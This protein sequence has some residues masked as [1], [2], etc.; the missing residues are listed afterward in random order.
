MDDA[1]LIAALR[2]S[3]TANMQGPDCR[4]CPYF[5]QEHVPEKLWEQLKTEWWDGCDVDRIAMDAAARLEEL[6]GGGR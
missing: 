2:C 4:N 5:T 6:T 1:K 3:A